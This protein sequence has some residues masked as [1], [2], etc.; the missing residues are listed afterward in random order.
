MGANSDCYVEIVALDA[1]GTN[2]IVLLV[3]GKNYIKEFRKRCK[4]KLE[5]KRRKY[6][7]YET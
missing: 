7:S 6:K 5:V 4:K 1:V 3:Y 2:G